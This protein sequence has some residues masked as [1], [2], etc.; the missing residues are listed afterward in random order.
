MKEIYWV[1]GLCLMAATLLTAQETRKDHPP[2]SFT[3]YPPLIYMQFFIA[4]PSD[5]PCTKTDSF[6]VDSV[7]NGCCTLTVTN[8]DG[9]G[10][11]EARSYEVFLNGKRVA[12]ADDSLKTGA[13]VAILR[14][15]KLRVILTGEPHSK[16]WVRIMYDPRQP[17]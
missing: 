5:A 9:R 14:R 4:C 6:T 16:M 12:S 10:T 7:P 17:N 3:G 15:N 1:A 2:Q 13:T 11:D 8:G